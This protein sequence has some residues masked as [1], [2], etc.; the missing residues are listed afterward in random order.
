MTC[1]NLKHKVLLYEWDE[2]LLKQ[3]Q[4]EIQTGLGFLFWW[5]GV[6][7]QGVRKAMVRK[8]QWGSRRNTHTSSPTAWRVRMNTDT[9]W[10]G[11]GQ[12]PISRQRQ[13]SLKSF[14]QWFAGPNTGIPSGTRVYCAGRFH[15]PKG[16]KHLWS[17]LIT[18]QLHAPNSVTTKYT[19]YISKHSQGKQI[20]Q[21]MT[22][23]FF[24]PRDKRNVQK[25]LKIQ[26]FYCG[27][28]TM[29]S[30]KRYREKKRYHS[31]WLKATGNDETQRT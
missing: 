5:A 15:L 27:P 3:T 1:E 12:V 21:W 17:L 24:C 26:N 19:L 10:E 6:G 7:V 9:I 4:H 22:R 23:F 25:S 30:T 14:Q 16:F 29:L 18:F 13:A 20:V 8:Q 11:C 31:L 28:N 2:F